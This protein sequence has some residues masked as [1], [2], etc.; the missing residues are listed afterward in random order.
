MAASSPQQPQ[1]A[2]GANGPRQTTS[3]IVS[4]VFGILQFVAL[5]LIAT[6]VALVAGYRSRNDAAANPALSD[7]LGKVGRILGWIGVVIA[8][9]VLGLGLLVGVVGVAMM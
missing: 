7:D 1:P 8:L 5:P 9:V 3:G 2:A 4:L 6:I